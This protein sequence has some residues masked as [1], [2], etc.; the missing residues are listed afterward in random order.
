MAER[1]NEPLPVRREPSAS[2]KLLSAELAA[3]L[4]PATE[5]VAKAEPARRSGVAA[6]FSFLALLDPLPPDYYFG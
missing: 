4:R 2:S 5:R 3:E 6:A 1:A